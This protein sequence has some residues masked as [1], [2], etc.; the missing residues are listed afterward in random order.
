M[1]IENIFT[2]APNP[3]PVSCAALCK[4]KS[5]KILALLTDGLGAGGGIARYNSDLM[6]ALGKCKCVEQVLALPRF[7]SA[8]LERPGRVV[9]LEATPGAYAWA[10]KAT[11]LVLA[12]RF[13]AIFCGHLNAAPLAAAIARLVGVPLWIQVHGI[14]AWR[15]RGGAFRHAL[16]SARLVTSVS[17]YTRRRLL[18]WSGLEPNVVRVLPNTLRTACLG[19]GTYPTELALQLGLEHSRVILTVGRL[20]EAER[21]K[22]HDRVISVL[23]DIAFRVPN[24]NYLIVGSGDDRKRLEALAHE[25]GVIDRVIFA[26]DVN[27]SQIDDYFQLADVFA[28][29]ST[30]EGFGIVYLEAASAGLPVIAGNRDGSADALLDGKYGSLIDPENK[31]QLSSSII[32]GLEGRLPLGTD[33]ID[34]FDFDNFSGQL[35]QLICNIL[36]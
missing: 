18:T 13:D 6:A 22:G 3:S 31:L 21:Y 5:V 24:V 14:E 26:S 1:Q 19:R 4:V 34:R 23:P 20:S 30:G 29:P 32:D 36:Q 35:E 25:T 28:M 8:V 2:G 17:R 16:A 12:R 11:G 33:V 15:D 10:L 9:Q 27:S 7:G